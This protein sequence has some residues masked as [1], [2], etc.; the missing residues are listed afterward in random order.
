MAVFKIA[1]VEKAWTECMFKN[2]S[3]LSC[4]SHPYMREALHMY[5]FIFEL[6]S[7]DHSNSFQFVPAENVSHA[8]EMIASGQAD[9]SSYLSRDCSNIMHHSFSICVLSSAA[10]TE[11]V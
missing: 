9:F 7:T 8:L 11:S 3:S 1:L 6:I 4:M 2:V 10:L 5:N